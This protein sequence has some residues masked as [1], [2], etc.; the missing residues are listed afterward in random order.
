MTAIQLKRDAADRGGWPALARSRTPAAAVAHAPPSESG[1]DAARLPVLPLGI[2]VA[3]DW[4]N[5]DELLGSLPR[6]YEAG[7]PGLITPAGDHLHASIKPQDG[8]LSQVM[9]E[10]VPFGGFDPEAVD[11]CPQVATFVCPGGSVR[12]ARRAMHLVSDLF[13]AGSA[14]V[15]ILTS[16]GAFTAET[17]REVATEDAGE[18]L[19]FTTFGREDSQLVGQPSIYSA[20]LHALG[21]P[22]AAV[23]AGEVHQVALFNLQEFISRTLCGG[24]VPDDGDEVMGLGQISRDG[25]SGKL[26]PSYRARRTACRHLPQGSPRHNPF[27]LFALDPL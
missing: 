20:G 19:A 26:I 7:R 3:G 6:G 1:D 22:D 9:A 8:R 24:E 2:V 12:R 21:W 4:A 11:R 17:W 14:G 27:G 5:G 13:D 16:G 10:G 15:L 25:T 23:P 18:L